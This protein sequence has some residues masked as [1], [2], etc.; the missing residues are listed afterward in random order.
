MR[1]T[2]KTI[3]ALLCISPLSA[4]ALTATKMGE[5]NH[6]FVEFDSQAEVGNCQESLNL[7]LTQNQI[8]TID[9]QDQADSLLRVRINEAPHPIR[10]S[11]SWSVQLIG[12]EE[13]KLFHDHG[14]DSEWNLEA[15]CYDALEDV[16]DDIGT[17]VRRARK[18]N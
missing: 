3:I 17:R 10:K 2:I 15:A 4:I 6:V 13:K 11:V 5:V 12:E 14:K 7:F 9:S 8:A 18:F 16:V 1:Q